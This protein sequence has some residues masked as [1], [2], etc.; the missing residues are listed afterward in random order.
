MRILFVTQFFWPETRTAPI[1]LGALAEDLAA[2]GHEV[3]VITS[4]PNH[5]LGKVYDGYKMKLW[6]WEEARG[7]KILR[8]PLFPDHSQSTFRRLL[9]YTSFTLSASTLGVWKTKSFQPDIIFAYFA[10]ITA[11]WT[12]R[13]IRAFHRAPVVYWITDLW[14][15]NFR[16]SGMSISDGAYARLRSFEDWGYKQ[17][18]VICVDSPGYKKN[19]LEKGVPEEKIHIVA[20]WADEQLFYPVERDPDLGKN[21]GL[22]GRF[23]I[24]YGGNLGP[25]QKL[26][27]VIEAARLLTDLEEIQFVF[28]GDGT[29]QQEL[30]SLVDEYNLHNVRFIP[31]QP[32]ERMRDFFAWADALLVHLKRTP[33]FELQL[34]SKV[35]AY[36][37]CE[38]PILN[39]VAGTVAEIID[40][41]QC[42][43]SFPPED[44]KALAGLVREFYALPADQRKA[45]GQS[46]R[47][48]YLAQYSR[49]IQVQRLEQ[50]LQD[51]VEERK[52]QDSAK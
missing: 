2:K 23:N 43:R 6:Q 45:M 36:M 27:T 38:R 16:A 44:P 24:L 4:V 8:L 33:I 17:A 1:N 9:N 48:T 28:I 5:P 20:E 47:A 32:M 10:P 46:G 11:A 41:A 14:P 31:R 13:T 34:P 3:L 19:L 51:V 50:I 49:S 42:G 30:K 18:R 22:T 29:A 26:D 52:R 39:G 35:L 21:F 40:Q 15:E 37:A 12:V 7:F 25:V